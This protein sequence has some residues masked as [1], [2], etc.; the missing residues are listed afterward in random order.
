[1]NS[2][3]TTT[4]GTNVTSPAA[5]L[6]PGPWTGAGTAIPGAPLTGTA[7]SCAGEPKRL[8]GVSG[9]ALPTAGVLPFLQTGAQRR[10][11]YANGSAQHTSST[12][13]DLPPGVRLS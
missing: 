10:P 12:P 8:R 7:M 3:D 13:G 6:R 4:V 1:M 11:T 2:T 9:D 5:V